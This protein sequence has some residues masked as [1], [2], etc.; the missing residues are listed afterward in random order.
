MLF[1]KWFWRWITPEYV[2]EETED[3]KKKKKQG[4]DDKDKKPKVK[5]VKA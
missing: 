5:Y 4:Q 1:E 3:D 2:P